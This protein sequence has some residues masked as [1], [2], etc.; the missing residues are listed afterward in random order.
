MATEPGERGAAATAGVLPALGEEVSGRHAERLSEAVDDVE[1]RV[2][3]AALDARNVGAVEVR[4]M[5]E[6]LLRPASSHPEFT[7]T[8]T[9]GN[10][11]GRSGHLSTVS[12]R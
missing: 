8:R 3:L 11:V 9:E 6:V 12:L 4:A 5:G 1:R 7:H 2:S 10:A